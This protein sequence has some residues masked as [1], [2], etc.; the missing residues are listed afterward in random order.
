MAN[1]SSY[2]IDIN[3]NNTP[4]T[5]I[6][7]HEL[8]GLFLHLEANDR[9]YRFRFKDRL[10][11]EHVLTIGDA[12]LLD[13]TD[14]RN[15]ARHLGRKVLL[16]ELNVSPS[17]PSVRPPRQVLSLRRTVAPS[18]YANGVCD[19]N[20]SPQPAPVGP[21]A[22]S[23]R[24]KTGATGDSLSK[25]RSYSF[26]CA[27]SEETPSF[28]S[29]SQSALFAAV[30]PG[31]SPAGLSMDTHSH[32]LAPVPPQCLEP[33]YGLAGDDLSQKRLEPIVDRPAGGQSSTGNIY[34][35]DVT[36]NDDLYQSKSEILDTSDLMP[37]E[38]IE[39]QK[40][41]SQIAPDPNKSNGTHCATDPKINLGQHND[42]QANK[43][44]ALHE[45]HSQ[46]QL[47]GLTFGEFIEK[48]YAPHAKMTKRGFVT[49]WSILKNHILPAL[50]H[51]PI[52]EISKSEIIEIVH[53]KLSSLKPGTI[54]RMINGLKVIF[55]RAIEW[56]LPGLE[57]NPMLGIKQFA[58]YSRHERYLTQEEA[59]K[60]MEAVLCSSNKLL[61]PIVS[62]LLLTGCR[63]REILDA[64]WEYVD[65]ERGILTVPL[66]KSGKPRQVV[67]SDAV[68]TIFLNTRTILIKEM[69]Q[70]ATEKCPWVFPNTETGKPFTGVFKS[71]DAAR[72]C[73]GL[74]D[75]RMHDLRHSFASA[76][77]NKGNSLYDVQKLLG[78][79]SSRM[80][81]RYAHLSAQR[82]TTVATEVS[83]H[84]AL[85]KKKAVSA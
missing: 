10:G 16:Q 5:V 57:K 64:R 23:C 85:P 61:A 63:K 30:V 46:P 27:L 81:E 60:L 70:E 31:T 49:E 20:T 71:W 14:A 76:L 38:L 13:I 1:K 3:D 51:R 9:T 42:F 40:L 35:T 58:N 33:S 82:L 17:R 69:G 62:A 59:A 7:D 56:E 29:Q 11:V 6:P 54:N 74:K 15:L 2:H 45:Q 55:S 22:V 79:S 80:T 75:L 24:P 44:L 37:I 19:A 4:G 52:I 77:V 78:H 43:L 39:P 41:Q 73:A 66:S 68:K 28:L 26:V 18:E 25:L 12:N 72:T 83:E 48:R 67:L 32:Q 65:L 8:A 21:S 34:A 36:G 53:G 50:A 47:A 84:Y